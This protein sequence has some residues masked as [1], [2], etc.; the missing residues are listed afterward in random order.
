MAQD[1]IALPPYVAKLEE[2]LHRELAG[3]EICYEQL[4]PD[5]YSFEVLWHG[6]DDM[7]HAD[8]Q[9]FVWNIVARTVES[10]DI[11]KIAMIRTPDAEPQDSGGP[12]ETQFA[13]PRPAYVDQ[14]IGAFTNSLPGA[15][16]DVEQ[17]RGDRYRFAVV[18]DQ[19]DSMEHP[20]RQEMV[21]N[22]AEKALSET[23]R[24]KVIMILTLGDV[25]LPQEDER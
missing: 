16:V 23:D 25:D 22:I 19:F 14:L 17:V 15:E 8:R 11:M 9:R 3:A 13:V 24:Y 20:E 4:R 10:A 21:W 7:D 6:F 12:A 5:R 18:W 1:L 2:A